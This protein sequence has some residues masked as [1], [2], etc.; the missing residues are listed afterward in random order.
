[1]SAVLV[2][3]SGCL[4]TS[5]YD[6]PDP[7]NVPPII[8]DDPV[9]VAKIGST[10]WLDS[11]NPM[12]WAFSVR[13]RDEDTE[14][15]LD[16]RWRLVKQGEPTPAFTILDPLPAGKLV[17]PTLTFQVGSTQLNGHVKCF[18]FCVLGRRLAW[19]QQD[20]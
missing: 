2:A 18:F 20:Y 7:T 15:E 13:V 17:R 10:I 14:Q 4:V 12:S 9:S 6:I 5:K 3:C 8:Q 16:A 1:M 11:E 19:F